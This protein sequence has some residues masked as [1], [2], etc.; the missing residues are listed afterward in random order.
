MRIGLTYDLR[1][2]YLA[3]GYSFEEVAE[4]DQ[5][6]TIE[7]IESV[8]HRLGHETDRIGHVRA[9]VSRLAAGDRWDLVFNIAEGMHGIARE[10]QVPALL[11]AY[12]IPYVFSDPL[13]CALTL[14]KATTKRVLRDLDIPTPPFSVVRAIGDVDWITL[15]FPLF[16][17]PVAEGTSKGIDRN[18]KITSANQLRDV[19]AHL[20]STFKQ[21]VLVEE[22][23]PGREFTV[24][25][26]GTA[27]AARTVG[28]M[29]VILLATAD[30]DVYTQLNKEECESRVRYTLAAGDIA[31]EASDLALQTWR[32]LG[33]RDGGR[34]DVRVGRDGRLQV[35]EINP[36][37]G[38]HPTHSDLPIM[39]TLA[40]MSYD[41]LI[42]EI[43]AS[44]L[45]RT[46][47]RCSCAHTPT[48]AKGS[49]SC[50][51]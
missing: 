18:S 20:L 10:A 7:A 30:S 27:D 36:L 3:E 39:C 28:V 12:Q 31:A 19:C 17:K 8:L 11:D 49:R 32:G 4:F 42:G 35:I 37:P 21:P 9:L 5:P 16:A 45:R 48:T 29:E 24:G 26:V 40:G 15:E 6:D 25:I 46:K 23:L 44:A 2:E 33:A 43:V 22:F 1:A 14:D 13:I 50:T 34:V 51:S 47:N 41:Q 38:L